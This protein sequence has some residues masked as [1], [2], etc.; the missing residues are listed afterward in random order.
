M[1]ESIRKVIHSQVAGYV[2]ATFASLLVAA[3]IYAVVFGTGCGETPPAPIPAPISWESRQETRQR[4]DFWVRLQANAR[5]ARPGDLATRTLG[6]AGDPGTSTVSYAWIPPGGATNISFLNIQ[7]D[8][9]NGPPPYMWRDRDPGEE[10]QI[11]YNH[12]PLPEG[13]DSMLSTETAVVGWMDD[14]RS[15]STSFTTLITNQPSPLTTF[16]A[17]EVAAPN[18]P[19]ATVDLWGVDWWMDPQGITMTTELCQDWF[20]L[21]QSDDVFLAMRMP[22]SPTAALTEGY[23]LP[24][25]FEGLYSNTLQLVSYDLMASVITAPLELRPERFTFL[26]NALPSA[27]GEHWMA[28]GLM[29][30]TVT[31]PQGLELAVD[32]WNFHG[33]SYL[34]LTHQPDGCE[35]CLLPAYYCYEGQESPWDLATLSS[36]LDENVTSYQGWGI[37]CLGPQPLSLTDDS[38]PSW[39]LG[40]LSA[41]WVTPTQSITL[42]HYISVDTGGDPMTLALDY[43]TTMTGVE[44]GIYGGTWAEPDLGDP[45]TLPV[46]VAEGEWK[47]VWMVSEPV[48]TSTVAG[49]YNLSLTATS[50][51][52]PSDFL[53]ASDVIWVGTWVAPPPPPGYDYHVYLPLVVKSP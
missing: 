7:P 45:I 24:I 52:S 11:N 39:H 47:V 46:P 23:P 1:R 32:G 44:W 33:Q 25:V 53:W 13:E 48:P 41:V 12:P 17:R 43:T 10:I 16:P 27:P 37:T 34:N 19:A 3:V 26:E 30:D 5:Q 31:C 38:S 2:Q 51:V 20:E 36:M 14:N 50:V 40:G 18:S 22:V 21:L 49:A 29:P 28:L 15:S 35:G 6:G 9:P 8:N 4:S 42:Q